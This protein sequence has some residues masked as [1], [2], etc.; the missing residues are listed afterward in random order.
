MNRLMFGGN[1]V[2]SAGYDALC[3]VLEVEFAEGGQI[4][5][6]M[7]VPEETWYQFRNGEKPDIFFHRKIKG[8]FMERQVIPVVE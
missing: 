2:T 7:N 6:Y 1:A 3:A 5:Q 8:C 4:R